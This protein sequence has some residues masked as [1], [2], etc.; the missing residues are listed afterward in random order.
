MNTQRNKVLVITSKDDAH[1]D[2]IIALCNS[3]G[4][5]ERIIRLNT[6]DFINNCQ[7]SFDGGSFHLVI[8]DSKREL[9]S[10][11]IRAVWYRRPKDFDLSQENDPY[12]E[13]FIRQQGTA[14][15]RGL[16][17]SCHDEAVWVNP[18]PALHRSRNKLQ[19]IQIVRQIG[20]DP[21][22]TIVTNNWQYAVS[23]CSNVEKI[24][25]KSL[26]EPNFVLDRH[27]YP[28]LTRVIGKE[29]V[30]SNRESIGR[31]PV[32]LQEYIDKMFDIRVVVIGEDIFAF[33]IHSQ[34]HKLSVHD[35]RGVAPDLLK[36]IHH[37]LPA[38]IREGIFSFMHRQ[39][40][41]FSAMDFVLSKEGKYY[42]L[43]NN[44]NGQWLWLEELTGVPLSAS[45]LKL[46]FGT[47]LSER[48]TVQT[49]VPLS[50]V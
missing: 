38:N 7:V 36:H 34:E 46:L 19:Q 27:L 12:V 21:P 33:E 40:L 2:H 48:Y 47:E 35:F 5:G 28:F 24:C 31:C 32:L 8:K 15:L 41:I 6:E 26:D 44:P 4:L 23:F 30:L 10:H 43:E 29:E 9:W 3:R 45:M 11:E 25:M 16:Y 42:F 37:E 50:D 14:C 13:D 22:K 1:A 18:L 49:F 39:G 20:L 17:F